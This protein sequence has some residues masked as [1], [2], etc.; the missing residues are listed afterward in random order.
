M[1]KWMKRS[2]SGTPSGSVTNANLTKL[3]IQL[4]ENIV[5]IYTFI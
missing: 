4:Y 2:A 5:T 3:T 1:D